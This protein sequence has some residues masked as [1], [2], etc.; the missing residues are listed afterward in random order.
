[1]GRTELRAL[2][3]TPE[4]FVAIEIQLRRFTETLQ[5]I[6]IKTTLGST[7]LGPVRSTSS[8]YALKRVLCQGEKQAYI[9]SSLCARI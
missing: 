5:T 3:R 6:V 9:W 4:R 1:M 2:L 8:K 7:A